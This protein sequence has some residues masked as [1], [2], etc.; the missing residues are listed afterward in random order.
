[1]PHKVNTSPRN[2]AIVHARNRR[3]L[4]D[5]DHDVGQCPHDADCDHGHTGAAE[6]LDGEDAVVESEEGEFVGA[7]AERIEDLGE[8]EILR[9]L[10][11]SVLLRI[12]ERGR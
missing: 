11:G 5:S 12:K 2:L 3:A 6:A 1:M 8:P 10:S 9:I 4:K 7:V